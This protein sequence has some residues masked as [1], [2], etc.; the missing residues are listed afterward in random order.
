MK[1]FIYLILLVTFSW[2]SLL[3]LTYAV[4]ILIVP[5]P[6]LSNDFNGRV[7]TQVLKALISSILSLAWLASL[8]MIRNYIARKTVLK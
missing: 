8:L 2:I 6:P 3:F 1:N 5:L 4:F 7:V